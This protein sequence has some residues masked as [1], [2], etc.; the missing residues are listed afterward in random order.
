VN[1][2]CGAPSCELCGSFMPR[3]V[4]FRATR[5]NLASDEQ[6]EVIGGTARQNYTEVVT[7]TDPRLLDDPS[8]DALSIKRQIHTSCVSS[9]ISQHITSTL[10]GETEIA[11]E[12]L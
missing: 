8:Q 4:Y 7:G 12:T 10:P 3:V 6:T 5:I 2:L 1:L 9:T 11:E